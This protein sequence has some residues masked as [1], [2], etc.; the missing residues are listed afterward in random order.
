MNQSTEISSKVGRGGRQKKLKKIMEKAL[1]KFRLP[2]PGSAR[3]DLLSLRNRDLKIGI[4]SEKNNF[5]ICFHSEVQKCINKVFVWAETSNEGISWCA[6]STVKI[7]GWLNLFLL[8][9]KRFKMTYFQILILNFSFTSAQ[10]LLN[11]FFEKS[12]FLWSV[13]N[14]KNIAGI[15]L[16]APVK[17]KKP[18][19]LVIFTGF[20]SVFSA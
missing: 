13:G 12:P 8:R 20:S 9:S 3:S 19:I 6:I 4:F 14:L 18:K 7:S 5:K 16:S 1:E 17:N 2:V 11:L 15:A 10:I